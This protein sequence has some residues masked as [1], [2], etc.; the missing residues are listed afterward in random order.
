MFLF[1]PDVFLVSLCQ[2]T[3]VEA[4][5]RNRTLN[6]TKLK[7]VIVCQLKSPGIIDCLGATVHNT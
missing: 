6:K 2:A 3:D 4:V 7:T 1:C 5:V